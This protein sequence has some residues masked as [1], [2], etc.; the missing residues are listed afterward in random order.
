MSPVLQAWCVS[1]R[2]SHY[3][4]G[5][6]AA[7]GLALSLPPAANLMLNVGGGDGVWTGPARQAAGAQE[8][9]EKSP[10]GPTSLFH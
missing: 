6:R 9:S 5:K 4:M 2:T 3:Q 7:M 10:L 1:H 8:D